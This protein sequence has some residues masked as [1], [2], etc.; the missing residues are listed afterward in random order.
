MQAHIGGD[1]LSE[2]DPWPE[3]AFVGG[4]PALDFV[5][6]VDDHDKQRTRS[7]IGDGRGF[8][9]WA[10]ASRAFTS[11]QL[12]VLEAMTRV[13]SPLWLEDVHALRET[14]HAVLSALAAGGEPPAG[15]W[16]VLESA[17]RT[18]LDRASLR[19]EEGGFVWR[20]RCEDASWV[21]DVLALSLEDL[22]RTADLRRLRECGRCSWLFIDRGRGRGRRWCDMR[23]CGNRAKVA[24]FKK[25]GG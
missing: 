7:R 1:Q 19:H 21:V 18:A 4:H 20:P 24:A 25:G 16:E 22:L 2:V 11:A 12:C 13:H 3:S 10:R 9:G 23:T 15:Q 17:M 14:A 6:T 8:L 5:N